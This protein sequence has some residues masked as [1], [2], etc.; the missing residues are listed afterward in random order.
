MKGDTSAT[1][2]RAAAHPARCPRCGY[3]LHGAMA[4]WPGDTCP[5]E[6]RCTECGLEFEWGDVLAADLREPVWAV[7]TD[8]PRRPVGRRVLGT[9]LH[10]R[11]PRR[12]WGR[13][14]MAQ[15]ARPRLLALFLVLVLLGPAATL[16]LVIQAGT[17]LVLHELILDEA[18]LAAQRYELDTHP[19]L[20]HRIEIGELDLD[21]DRL[22][23]PGPPALDVSR[24]RAVWLAIARP[25]RDR[26]P[27]EVSVPWHGF[28]Y[29]ATARIHRATRWTL[30]ARPFSPLSDAFE[31]LTTV[32]ASPLTTCWLGL[33]VLLPASMALAPVTLRRH[34]V[35]PYHVVRIAVYGSWIAWVPPVLMVVG[36]VLMWSLPNSDLAPALMHWSPVVG[37]AVLVTW[38]IAALH[39]YV[40]LRDGW[41]VVATLLVLCVLADLAMAWVLVP[42]GGA[43]IRDLL[44]PGWP[45]R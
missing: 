8:R 11:R 2:R 14:S 42:G 38:W 39:R 32:F 28:D 22:Q 34:R 6:G 27:G 15:P 16:Y 3:D 10:A 26:S 30:G 9:L 21:A 24:A 45:Y 25:L 41:V 36:F 12:F 37:L 17:A 35:R 29:P 33:F 40:R 43:R 5:L 31:E 7:E 19:S 18:A 44:T 1:D 4:Q 13:L 20:L 23:P